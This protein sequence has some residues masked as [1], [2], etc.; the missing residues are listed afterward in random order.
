MVSPFKPSIEIRF[1]LYLAVF[2]YTKSFKVK[3][4]YCDYLTARYLLTTV[5]IQ[6]VYATT[7]IP[8]V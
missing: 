1:L 4:T 8:S 6:V 5:V 2:K 3:V 7:K